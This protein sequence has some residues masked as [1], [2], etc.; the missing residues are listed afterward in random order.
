PLEFLW[1][2]LVDTVGSY[3]RWIAGAVTVVALSLIAAATHRLNFYVIVATL[4]IASATQDIAVDAFTIRATP[5]HLL[6]PINSIRVAAYRVALI[7]G[8]GALL[9]LVDRT[10]WR[11][12]FVIAAAIALGIFVF[13]LTL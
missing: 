5:Q 4:A 1:S 13:A 12:V 11:F 2:P 10:S 3:R 8:G 7:V 6:G 9:A